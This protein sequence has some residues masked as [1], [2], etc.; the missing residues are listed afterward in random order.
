MI[1]LATIIILR[2]CL[3]LV[4]A[5]A[6]AFV[7][8]CVV[9]RKSVM[10]QQRCCTPHMTT[11]NISSM[12]RF[13]WCGRYCFQQQMHSLVTKHFFYAISAYWY[14]RHTTYHPHPNH[15]DAG[16]W[17][18]KVGVTCASRDVFPNCFKF[19]STVFYNLAKKKWKIKPKRTLGLKLP[20]KFLHYKSPKVMP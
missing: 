13:M 1:E 3:A 9:V 5:V 4:V 10:L 17:K 8:F 2:P 15:E 6:N 12:E 14:G 20:T 7:F 11:N 18:M 19:P 16:H